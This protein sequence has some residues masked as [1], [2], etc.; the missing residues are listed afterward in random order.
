VYLVG[1][2]FAGDE[3]WQDHSLLAL[4]QVGGMGGVIGHACFLPD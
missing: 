4:G 2:T 1:E 3:W